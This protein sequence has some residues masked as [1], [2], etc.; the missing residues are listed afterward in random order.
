VIGESRCE[1]EVLPLKAGTAVGMWDG[2]HG[3]NGHERIRY[4]LCELYFVETIP[5]M[6]LVAVIGR[7]SL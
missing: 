6:I 4:D 5:D 1:A 3:L 7:G 2:V